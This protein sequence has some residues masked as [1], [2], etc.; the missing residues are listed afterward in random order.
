[1]KALLLLFGLLARGGL[2][3]PVLASRVVVNDGDCTAAIPT[4]V[5]TACSTIATPSYTGT[6]TNDGVLIT[7]NTSPFNNRKV[8]ETTWTVTWKNVVVPGRDMD[9]KDM[10]LINNAWPPPS[11]VVSKGTII[12]IN[13]LNQ[14]GD[15]DASLHAHGLLQKG[16]MWMDGPVGVT[17]V[18]VLCVKVLRLS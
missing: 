8:Y 14:L 5:L 17:Q 18:Y 1:M 15:E 16:N 10:M 13:F 11:V 7:D 2:S 12:K 6:P 3:S 4:P 9:C